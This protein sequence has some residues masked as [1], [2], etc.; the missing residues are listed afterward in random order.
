VAPADE[1]ERLPQQWEVEKVQQL[2]VPSMDAERHLI[3]IK[4]E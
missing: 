1:R 4:K 2:K 3:F